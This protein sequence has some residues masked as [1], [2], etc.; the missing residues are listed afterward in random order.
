MKMSKAYIKSLGLAL[1]MKQ[2]YELGRQDSL[3]ELLESEREAFE[4]LVS[5]FADESKK[6]CQT[7][8]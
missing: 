1:T 7:S 4:K 2:M 6:T 8:N 3:R 5:E